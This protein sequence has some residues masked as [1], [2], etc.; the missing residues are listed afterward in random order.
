MYRNNSLKAKLASD[1]N[2]IGCWLSLGS[3]SA[4]E[5][6]AQ[7]GFDA[8]LIDHEHGPPDLAVAVDQLRAIWP[9][10]ATL[11]MRIAG[12]GSAHV[13]QALDMGIEG[14]VIPGVENAADAE[15]VVA[16]CRFPPR[17]RRGISSTV[18]ASTYGLGF[19]NYLETAHE[20]LLIMCQIESA[21][22]VENIAAIA[23]V[24]GVDVLFIGP[25]DLSGSI[26][27][28]AA[29]D[30][31]EVKAL[32][33]RAEQRIVDSGKPLGGVP[34][35]GASAKELFA[36]G[37]RFVTPASDSALLREAARAAAGTT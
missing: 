20:N 36:R 1:Q 28:P 14:L 13:R 26:G 17:G 31:P 22:A 2:C 29:F 30:D 8:L 32:F 37:Y 27:K 18:R 3:A 10:G 34:Y 25:N 4:A 5:I 6:V 16:A 35:G 33:E 11:L 19:R 21:G 23:A 24:D 7:A 12:H 15:A 9:S